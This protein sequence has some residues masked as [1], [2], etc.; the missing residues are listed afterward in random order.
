MSMPMYN[1]LPQ[2]QKKELRKMYRSRRFLAGG[3]L[4]FLFG[5]LAT[6]ALIPSLGMSRVKLEDVLQRLSVA[7]KVNE[8]R[9]GPETR[10]AIEESNALL[11][12]LA[13]PTPPLFAHN[14]FVETVLSQ[15]TSDI[16]LTG[17]FYDGPAANA[18]NVFQYRLRGVAQTREALFSF[19]EALKTEEEFTMVDV[20]ISNFVKDSDIDF[21]ITIARTFPTAR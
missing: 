5:A 17:I 18:K 16:R 1:L 8:A 9:L 14:G 21:S 19:V 10:A 2:N 4:L 13:V 20:P 11:A 6:V 12:V 15:R 3:V 7:R